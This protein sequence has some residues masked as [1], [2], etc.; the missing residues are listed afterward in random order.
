MHYGNQNASDGEDASN[1]W[2]DNYVMV[3]HMGEEETIEL[4]KQVYF[5]YNRALEYRQLFFYR[6]GLAYTISNIDILNG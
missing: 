1:V 5:E 6:K 4:T 2:D 3:Q